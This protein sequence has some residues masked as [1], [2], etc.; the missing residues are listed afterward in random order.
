ME[1]NPTV[2]H[3]VSD[4]I[5]K[6]YESWDSKKPVIIT[7]PTGSGKTSFILE[8]LLPYAM[9]QNKKI[10]YFVNRSALKDQLDHKIGKRAKTEGTAL[11]DAITIETYQ[12]LESL[13]VSPEVRISAKHK[14]STISE[15]YDDDYES[16]IG[17][18][19]PLE[20]QKKMLSDNVV[21]TRGSTKP[22]V[23]R[24]TPQSPAPPVSEPNNTLDPSAVAIRL[25][26]RAGHERIEAWNHKQIISHTLCNADYVIFDESHFFLSDATFN[27]SIPDYVQKLHRLHDLNPDAVWIFMTATDA[28]LNIFLAHFFKD[29]FKTDDILLS[30]FKSIKDCKNITVPET[31]AELMH[32]KECSRNAINAY[33]KRK[34]EV[35]PY[36][37]YPCFLPFSTAES[38]TGH[39]NARFHEYENL[40]ATVKA[41]CNVYSSKPD[42]S[43]IDPV[44]FH[45]NQ[46]IVDAILCSDKTEKWIIFVTNENDGKDFM[47]RL[48]GKDV[49]AVFIDAEDK[50]NPQTISK[51][52][53]RNIV[54]GEKFTTRVLITTSAL[55]NGINICD[56]D[57]KNI[58]I[59]SLNATT[60]LQMLGRKRLS[61]KDDRVRLFLRSWTW[62]RFESHF[63]RTLI[64]PLKK[65]QNYLRIYHNIAEEKPAAKTDAIPLQKMTYAGFIELLKPDFKTLFHASLIDVLIPESI[66][67]ILLKLS[68]D[69]YQMASFFENEYNLRVHALQQFA[70]R[71][72]YKQL[73]D[74]YS[75]PDENSTGTTYV[76]PKYRKYENRLK[77]RSWSSLRM[78]MEWIG[79]SIGSPEAPQHPSRDENWFGI[80]CGILAKAR[81]KIHAALS[82]TTLNDVMKRQLIEGLQLYFRSIEKGT[83]EIEDNCR[84]NTVNK[85][86]H[87]LGIEMKIKT[88]TRQIQGKKTT[89]WIVISDNDPA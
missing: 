70:F 52:E 57:V 18:Y 30:C 15:I 64:E 20:G 17:S 23:S 81:S 8:Q 46:N 27:Y 77:S 3:S 28:Y 41:H 69:F 87:T 78:Q 9:E 13:T 86:L 34:K 32:T 45:K 33:Y 21:V 82:V 4:L 85:Y 47:A 39:F 14:A 43:Y 66:V 55:D 16:K 71:F 7:A 75:V 72:I 22:S 40:S 31:I 10:F 2:S 1:H 73:P 19:M 74:K 76:I 67:Y 26:S 44:Y 6:D 50:D 80:R 51:E 11:L 48:S 36:A 89:Q 61:E 5:G 24:D 37:N 65:I 68:Y 35:I 12:K 79:R 25:V 60:F 49:T 54:T 63:N 53:Y 42:Y 83:C 56:K 84:A 62:N 29:T 88:V 38:F 59:F 58:V